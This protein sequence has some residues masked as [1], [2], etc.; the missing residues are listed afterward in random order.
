MRWEFAPDIKRKICFLVKKLSLDYISHKRIFCF[1]SFGSKSNAIARI[2]AL[3][4]IWQKAL[5]VKP[6]YCIE[7]ISEKFDKMNNQEKEEVLI[8]ELKHIPKNFSG[9]LLGHKKRK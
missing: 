3:P 2:W 8:H 4:K 7:V 9:T 1:R 5:N 6:G